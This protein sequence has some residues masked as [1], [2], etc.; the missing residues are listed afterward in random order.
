MSE[1][2]LV[3]GGSGFIGAHA[4]V[5]LLQSGRRVRAMLRS[6]QHEADVRAMLAAGGIQAGERLCFAQADLSADAGWE[7]AVAGCDYALHIA[8][9]FPTTAPE[10][11]AEIIGP[12]RDGALRVLSA[13]RAAGVKRVV[14]TSSFA[15]IGYG[16]PPRTEP[17]T[18]EDWTPLDGRD[19]SAYVKSKVIAERAAWAFIASEGAPMQLTV[20]NPVAVLGPVLGQDLSASIQ[21][22]KGLMDGKLPGCPRLAFGI[23]DVRDVVDLHLRAM[24][25]PD[26]A[27]QRFI[28]T[29]G[30]S[31]WMRDI[32]L[33][34]KQHLGA[35]AARVPTR[36]LPDFIVK[37]AA[38]VD[39]Q[40]T[41]ELGRVKVASNEKAKRILAWVPRTN[42]EAIVAT[43]Q[44]LVRL[45]QVKGVAGAA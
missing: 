37:L 38:L 16:H 25:H 22:V 12:A 34:L 24:T 18:E 15:A 42:E 17:F 29:N 21:L 7:A 14:L 44:S 33:I 5:Q 1:L 30:G 43:A 9:P 6:L 26:A 8:S 2:V 3:T 27:G 36:R 40:L 39:A 10:T 35:A 28:A 4:I 45:G 23:V 13:A 11:E 41:P 19:T 20:V 31:L 32:A